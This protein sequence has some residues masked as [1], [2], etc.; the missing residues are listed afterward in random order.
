M[1]T[2]PLFKVGEEV[3]LQSISNPQFNGE[4][5]VEDIIAPK[6]SFL[7]RNDKRSACNGSDTFGYLLNE[8]FPHKELGHSEYLWSELALRKKYPPS[9]FTFDELMSKLKVDK[10]VEID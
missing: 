2:Q 8:I 10:P 1:G 5:V 7:S 9:E 6:E 4:Y 3:I